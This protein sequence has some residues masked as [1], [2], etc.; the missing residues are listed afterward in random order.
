[1]LRAR[2][3]PRLPVAD[4]A[5]I[6]VVVSRAPKTVRID[7]VTCSRQITRDRSA[8]FRNVDQVTLRDAN[9]TQ[10]LALG[11]SAAVEVPHP[12]AICSNYFYIDNVTAGNAQE[13]DLAVLISGRVNRCESHVNSII[14]NIIPNKSRKLWYQALHLGSCVIG[15]PQP[16]HATIQKFDLSG[17]FQQY[18]LV[19]GVFILRDVLPGVIFAKQYPTPVGSYQIDIRRRSLAKQQHSDDGYQWMLHLAVIGLLAT[20]MGQ[21]P[22]IGHIHASCRYPIPVSIRSA[23]SVGPL[24]PP[25]TGPTA[26]ASEVPQL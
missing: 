11:P 8:S 15:E 12:A 4:I 17:D 19:A 7:N 21:L 22:C 26:V 6:S 3:I 2:T 9:S 25:A 20:L 24:N 16:E 14:S 18:V 5:R 13:T 10:A 23:T 1:M